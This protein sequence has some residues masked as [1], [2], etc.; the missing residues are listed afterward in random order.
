MHV[1]PFELPRPKN[2]ADFER[3]CAQI[4][5]VVFGDP[6]P[7]INGRKG[8]TQGGVDVFVNATVVCICVQT[9]VPYEQYYRRIKGLL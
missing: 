6:T 8:Q 5:G 4:Y 2:E 3:M 9:D 7:K 1:V